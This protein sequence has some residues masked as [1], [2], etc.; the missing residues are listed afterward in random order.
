[1]DDSETR[2]NAQ[3][4]LAVRDLVTR[5]RSE[6]GYVHAVNG[7]SFDV[8]PGETLGIVGES[9]SGKSV[10]MM[11]I[12]GLVP[13]P[14]AEVVAGEAT[15]DGVDLLGLS[16]RELRKV[17]GDKIAMIFQDPMTSLNPV[18]KVGNQIAETMKVHGKAGNRRVSSSRVMRLLE[19]VG[20]SQPARRAQQYPFEFSGGMR[21]RA[22]AA[23]AMANTP[24]VLVADEPT[25]ALD[26]TIQAQV[27]ETLDSI[28]EETGAALILITHDLGVIAQM[29]D[30]VA[31][32]YAGRIVETGQV[33]DVFANPRHPYTQGLLDCIPNL[34]G[35]RGLTDPIPGSPPDL[36]VLPVG[37]PFQPRCSLSRERAVCREQRPPLVE[38]GAFP[39]RQAACHFSDELTSEK[40]P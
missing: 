20:I 12:L 32:M 31:V 38:I 9:G 15:L 14:P 2:M 18:M 6:D 22:M 11:S 10:T 19:Q 24:R 1:M 29:A 7:V 37:C 25:T 23:I 4:V 21:Q 8:F 13:T 33:A 39:A 36:S 16:E 34:S 30:R 26:V 17:R 40:S 5:F 28:K 35:D 3:P 27:L